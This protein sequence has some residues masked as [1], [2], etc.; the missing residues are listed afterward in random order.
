MKKY[1]LISLCLLCLST[2]L[3]AQPATTPDPA[4]T[5][6]PILPENRQLYLDKPAQS[7]KS[8]KYKET[9]EPLKGEL[10]KDG[11]RVFIHNYTR[12]ARVA[13]EVRYLDGTEETIERSPC[14]I[15]PA[16]EM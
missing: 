14:F 9:G 12:R 11:K 10:S 7:I 6:E 13:V 3:W 15:D 2:H 4:A 8:V 16:E 5:P 1:I